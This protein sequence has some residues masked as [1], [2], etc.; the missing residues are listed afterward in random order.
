M[1]EIGKSYINN[2]IHKY[3]RKRVFNWNTV[4]PHVLDVLGRL[5]ELIEQA[6][7][8]LQAIELSCYLIAYVES[9]RLTA[10]HLTTHNNV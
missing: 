2:N 4:R 1:F 10:V 9:Y 8:A 3:S 5:Q 7:S 6:L